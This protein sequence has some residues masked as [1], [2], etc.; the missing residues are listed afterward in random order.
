MMIK[1]TH[2]LFLLFTL[3]LT[4]CGKNLM[5]GNFFA[6]E[7]VTDAEESYLQ[8]YWKSELVEIDHIGEINQN[9]L[10]H[11][12]FNLTKSN[13]PTFDAQLKNYDCS[14][15]KELDSVKKIEAELHVFFQYDQYYMIANLIYTTE[16]DQK[17]RCPGDLGQG[18]YITDAP[19]YIFLEDLD[20][21]IHFDKQSTGKLVMRFLR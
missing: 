7:E 4:S 13:R 6:K 8:G 12:Q 1:L 3:T 14:E 17:L 16:D 11:D 5:K 19:S 18:K 20:I 2:I 10:I 15:V 21:G 9:I